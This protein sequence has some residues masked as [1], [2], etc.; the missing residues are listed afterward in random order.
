MGSRVQCLTASERIDILY[1]IQVHH[2]IHS[3]VAQAL[4]QSHTTISHIFN[5]YKLHGFVNRIFKPS[6]KQVILKDRDQ[7]IQNMVRWQR[8]LRD[9]DQQ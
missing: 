7:Y 4:N 2:L 5:L 8:A 3:N 1:L 9:P 6:T